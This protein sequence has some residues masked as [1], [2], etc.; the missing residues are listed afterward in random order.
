VDILT[1]KHLEW[2]RRRFERF[3][4]IVDELLSSDYPSGRVRGAKM[5]IGLFNEAYRRL[6]EEVP[7]SERD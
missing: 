5:P 2:E 3:L 4:E 6:E 1:P 7:R